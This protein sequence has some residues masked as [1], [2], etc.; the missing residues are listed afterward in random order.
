MCHRSFHVC[1][2]IVVSCLGD[3]FAQ[4]CPFN[5]HSRRLSPLP[6]II[7]QV[8]AHLHI[9]LKQSPCETSLSVC[10]LYRPI[11]SN[12]SVKIDEVDNNPG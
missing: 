2:A 8:Y 7:S 6:H 9:T 1:N 4:L 3:L 5:V 10:T 12:Q 11:Y